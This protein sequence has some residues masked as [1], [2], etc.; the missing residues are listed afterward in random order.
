MWGPCLDGF[1]SGGGAK[2]GA[3]VGE[4]DGGDGALV[5]GESVLEDVGLYCG[6]FWYG[7]VFV[8]WKEKSQVFVGFKRRCGSFVN[9]KPKLKII[10]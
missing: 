8:M 7:H 9:S 5:G 10:K 6:F 2:K 1:V 4:F 3:V